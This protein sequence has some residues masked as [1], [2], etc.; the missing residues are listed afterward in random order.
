ML[1]AECVS[2]RVRF[3]PAAARDSGSPGAVGGFSTYFNYSTKSDIEILTRDPANSV[4]YSN[5]PMTDDSG[6]TVPGPIWNISM[7]TGQLWAD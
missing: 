4:R 3:D 5:Q 1:V 6:T 7:P 2:K